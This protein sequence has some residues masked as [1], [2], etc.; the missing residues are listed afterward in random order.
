MTINEDFRC[1][2]EESLGCGASKALLHSLERAQDDAVTSV[3]RNSAKFYKS[4]D[5]SANCS[6]NTEY[7]PVAWCDAGFYLDKRINFTLDPLL[8]AGCYYVQDASSMF[9]ALL[10]DFFD[11]IGKNGRVL[12]LCAAPGGK[13]TH[14]I[15]ILNDICAE[16]SSE[17]FDSGTSVP[18]IIVNEAMRKRVPPLCDNIARWGA[19][20]VLVTNR[21][22]ND[23]AQ[24]GEG[25]FD[26]IL[27]DVPCS[28]EGM[29]RKSQ[30]AIDGWSLSAVKECAKTQRDII[31]DIWSALKEDGILIYSTCTY[32]HFENAD[33]VAFIASAL[34]AEVVDL[35]DDE[36]AKVPGLLK[37]PI[38]DS[39]GYQFVP[40][41]VAGEG[42]FFAVLRK[43]SKGLRSNVN[44]KYNGRSNAKNNKFN[45]KSKVGISSAKNLG[46]KEIILVKAVADGV[47]ILGKISEYRFY[48]K[49]NQI[50]ALPANIASDMVNAAEILR[51]QMCG[52]RLCAIKGADLIPD[53]DFALSQ[54][55]LSC[56]C[57][58]DNSISA[59]FELN[60]SNGFELRFSVVDVDKEQAL[61]FLA[62]QDVSLLNFAEA[63]DDSPDLHNEIK[64]TDCP[65]KMNTVAK[66]YV[67]ITYKG[68]PLGFVKN[69]GNRC[70]NLY[71]LGRRIL[72]LR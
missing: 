32:N 38:G 21:F 35:K 28:G 45:A 27:A 59:N 67:L 51:P 10:T 7:K 1:L 47:N 55:L 61:R 26:F 36:L 63:G 66:G 11:V 8:H 44:P 19:S 42:Q 24:L 52:V 58:S 43:L 9:P 14:L 20:N 70:N 53:A 62:K 64:N 46:Y 57:R 3:R 65:G 15:S 39:F 71:P 5:K 34:G 54:I 48:L 12:D 22:A 30:D 33:N 23:I 41:L 37:I 13:S 29:F 50:F 49:E 2:I 72:N 18:L 16:S 31:H 40:G 60:F 17:K 6:E 56:I 25:Y 4:T 69:L 68:Y